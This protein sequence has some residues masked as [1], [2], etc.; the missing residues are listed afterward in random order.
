MSTV[1]T[2]SGKA[3]G[4]G[5]RN[6]RRRTAWIVLALLAAAVVWLVSFWGVV[7]KSRTEDVELAAGDVVAT[8]ATT[9]IRQIMLFQLV[10]DP[11]DPPLLYATE[12]P[13]S[14]A[15]TPKRQGTSKY[16]AIALF[17]DM[18]YGVT[19]LSYPLQPGG[20]PVSLSLGDDPD[21]A[22]TGGMIVHEAVTAEYLNGPID[23]SS[24]AP[25][26]ALRRGVTT[27]DAECGVAEGA[28]CGGYIQPAA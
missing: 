1:G 7:R 17:D 4:S 25:F 13:F 24:I 28:R 27:N 3:T 18:T 10:V 16:S 20:S 11:A 5:S 23:I 15:F 8:S 19:G 26:A 14:M 22:I 21:E 6:R 2:P 12:A 9:S